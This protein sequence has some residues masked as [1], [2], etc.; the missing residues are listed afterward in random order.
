MRADSIRYLHDAGFEF[1]SVESPDLWTHLESHFSGA[2][3]IGLHFDPLPAD[4]M[5][6]LIA[7]G[8]EALLDA[9]VRQHKA[10]GQLAAVAETIDLPYVIGIDSAIGAA[11]AT[12]G[13]VLALIDRPGTVG[14]RLIHVL[15]TPAS[16]LPPTRQATIEGGVYLDGH[17]VGFYTLH[18]GHHAD[19]GLYRATPTEIARLATDMETNADDIAL[20]TRR[21]C[22]AM[23][24]RAQRAL[25]GELI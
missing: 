14:E 22:D 24:A 12:H 17:T 4:R 3:R 20:I 11:E 19:E 6:A 2:G 15:P 1:K 9:L 16:A 8:E 18:P 13:E 10:T 21:E 25:G 5:N 7:Q 23:I